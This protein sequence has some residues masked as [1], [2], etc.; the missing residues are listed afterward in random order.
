LTAAEAMPAGSSSGNRAL[1]DY[2]HTQCLS[3][4]SCRQCNIAFCMLKQ[5]KSASRK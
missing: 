5:N 4:Q 2:V 3:R 1:S